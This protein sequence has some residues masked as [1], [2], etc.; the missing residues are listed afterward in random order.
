ML[1]GNLFDGALPLQIEPDMTLT[2]LWPL[3]TIVHHRAAHHAMPSGSMLGCSCW[4]MAWQA[5]A[6]NSQ[7]QAPWNF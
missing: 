2:L 4:V 7:A 5:A 1:A 6:E 3:L